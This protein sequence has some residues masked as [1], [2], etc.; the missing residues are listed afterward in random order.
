[1]FTE[2]TTSAQT[3][4]T[5]NRNR[6]SLVRLVIVFI[7]GGAVGALLILAWNNNQALPTGPQNNT[8][9]LSNTSRTNTTGQGTTHK[10]SSTLRAGVFTSNASSGAVSVVDQPAGNTVMVQSVT[11]PP[12]GVWLAVRETKGKFLSNILGAAR[13]HGPRSKVTVYLLRNTEPNRTYVVELYRPHEKGS[14]F[15]YKADSVYVDFDTGKPVI[16]PFRT[17]AQNN[18]MASTSPTIH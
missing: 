9:G 11:V 15:D 3:Q 8:S 2:N 6:E 14:G 1:M 18:A 7:A 10:G 16:V 5:H 13:V 4:I 12:P 17:T